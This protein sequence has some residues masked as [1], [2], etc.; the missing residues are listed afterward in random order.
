M[1]EEL[2]DGQKRIVWEQV[3]VLSRVSLKTDFFFQTSLQLQD[4]AYLTSCLRVYALCII[5]EFVSVFLDRYTT[6][7][8]HV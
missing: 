6:N 3:N 8:Y 2:F 4:V 1:A 7:L 5:T